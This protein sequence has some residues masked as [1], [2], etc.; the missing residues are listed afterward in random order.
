MKRIKNG[1]YLQII[2]CRGEAYRYL[3]KHR[4]RFNVVAYPMPAPP[5]FHALIGAGSYFSPFTYADMDCRCAGLWADFNRE[6]TS[7]I[8]S[9]NCDLTQ[10]VEFLRLGGLGYGYP[11]YNA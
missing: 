3:Q 5:N 4:Y 10:L 7:I 11:N 8:F 1:Q 6:G 2:T 9:K